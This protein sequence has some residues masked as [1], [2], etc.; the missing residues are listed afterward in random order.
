[1][2]IK[3]AI[4][5]AMNSTRNYYYS[6][7][8][9]SAVS[10]ID[11]GEALYTALAQTGAFSVEF[12]DAL[13]VGEQSGNLDEYFLLLADQYQEGAQSALARLAALGGFFVWLLVAVLIISIIINIVAGYAGFLQSLT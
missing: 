1:M 10:A 4:Q 6:K 12:L 13:E 7:H 9:E 2:G 11:D 5:L 3:R 8:T